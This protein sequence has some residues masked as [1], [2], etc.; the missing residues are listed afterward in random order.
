[1]IFRAA[2]GGESG[3]TVSRLCEAGPLPGSPCRS[4]CCLATCSSACAASMPKSGRRWKVGGGWFGPAMGACSSCIANLWFSIST[5]PCRST[6][7]PATAGDEVEQLQ[8]LPAALR[9]DVVWRLA[10]PA[11]RACCLLRPLPEEVRPQ[12]AYTCAVLLHAW[13]SAVSPARDP[14]TQLHL[15]CCRQALRFLAADLQP[16]HTPAGLDFFKQGQA[17]EG[18][19]YLLTAGEGLH[20]TRPQS[21][22]RIW[23]GCPA[24]KLAVWC[25][26]EAAILRG[27]RCVATVHAPALLGQA[28]LLEPHAED[29]PEAATRLHTGGWVQAGR[30]SAGP[31]HPF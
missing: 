31:H 8:A 12:P 7:N 11:L 20:C 18:R 9:A 25:A 1:M 22:Q 15:P 30:A 16:C 23:Y 24:N 21:E 14:I 26:G 3:A 19:C 6:S 4:A 28:A 17:A 13:N 10:G 27:W 5:K 2:S 29:C